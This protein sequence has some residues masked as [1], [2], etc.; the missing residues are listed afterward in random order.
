[1]RMERE[2]YEKEIQKLKNENEALTERELLMVEEIKY[3]HAQELERLQRQHTQTIQAALLSSM[4]SIGHGVCEYC[5]V[6]CSLA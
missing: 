2:A 3:A 5:T 4:D 6:R 1:M